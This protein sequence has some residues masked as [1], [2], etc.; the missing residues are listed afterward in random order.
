MQYKK[1]GAEFSQGS[2]YKPKA[3]SILF[4]VKFQRDD[5]VVNIF[6]LSE[7]DG[8]QGAYKCKSYMVHREYWIQKC[9]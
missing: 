8:F 1:L 7:L 2:E 6:L 4:I 3:P 9:F 5:Y